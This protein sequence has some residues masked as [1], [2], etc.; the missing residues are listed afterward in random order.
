MGK[1][2]KPILPMLGLLIA[3]P[4]VSTAATLTIT[5]QELHFHIGANPPILYHNGSAEY[6]SSLGA[7]NFGAYGWQVTNQTA[8]TWTQFSIFFF[9]DAEWDISANLVSNEY[10]EFL[11]LGLAPGAPPGAFAPSAWEIDEPGYVFG[12][13]YD[14]V[15]FFGILDGMNAVPSS[16]PDD[17]SLALG[18]SVLALAPGESISITIQHLSASTLGIGHFDP[19][20]MGAVYVNGW[21]E[22]IAAPPGPGGPEIPEPSTNA[23][24]GLGLAAIGFGIW[25]RNQRN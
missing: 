4:L 6:S 9:L 21:M 8:S 19:D 13:I 20:S 22:I 12:D 16:S 25:N 18:W 3:V 11:G 10:A 14:N 23:L 17:V 2:M 15:S 24:G 1:T 7:G 5:S